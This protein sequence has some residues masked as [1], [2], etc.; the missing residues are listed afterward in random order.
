MEEPIS[1]YKSDPQ[2]L[3]LSFIGTLE[4]LA[5]QSKAQMNFLLLDI[6]TTLKIELGSILEKLTQ[7]HIRREH[8]RFDM[9]QDDCDNEHCASTQFSQIQKKSIN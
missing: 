5:S 7:R 1:L 6:K 2:H 9:S 3:V 4:G 8:T